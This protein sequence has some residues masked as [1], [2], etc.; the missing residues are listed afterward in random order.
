MYRKAHTYVLQVPH[1][2]LKSENVLVTSSLSV[3]ITDFA[4]SF[5]QVYLPLN[6]PSDFNFYFGTSGRRT[7][8][9]APERFYS[10]DS[11]IA[12]QKAKARA[13]VEANASAS[14]ITNDVEGAPEL[15]K[16]D[17]KVTEAMDVFSLGCVIAELW[18]DGAPIFTLMQLFKYREGLF[19][20]EPALAEI[21]DKDIRD[22]VRSMISIDPQKRKSFAEYLEHGRRKP[23]ADIFYTFLHRYLTTLQRTSPRATAMAAAE[24]AHSAS[25]AAVAAA[26]VANVA[27]GTHGAP[28]TMVSEAG[29]VSNSGNADLAYTLRAEA[30]ERVERLYEEWTV[31]IGMLNGTMAS[32]D[33][34]AI[35]N[36][37]NMDGAFSPRQRTATPFSDAGVGLSEGRHSD[38]KDREDLNRMLPIRISIPGISSKLIR[39]AIPIEEDG[40]ALLILSPLLANM[41]NALRPSTKLHALDLLLHLSSQWL[42]D[43]TKLDRVLPYIIALFNDDSV[44]VRSAA[45][46][47]VVQLLLMVD[48]ITFSNALTFSEYVIPNLRPLTRD[49]SSLVRSTYAACIVHLIEIGKHYLQMASAMRGENYSKADVE[50]EAVQDHK[51]DEFLDGNTSPDNAR[52]DWQ[53]ASLRAFFQEQATILL[54]DSSPAVKR[55][56]LDSI[57]PLCIFFGAGPTNDVL[58]SHM[59]TYLNDRSWLLRHAFFDAIIHVAKVAGPRS[60]EEYILPLMLQTLSDPEEFVVLRVIEGL[61]RLL[62]SD[63]ILS[64]GRIYDIVSAVAGFLCHP[65]H[66][67]R[68][69]SAL[70]IST[71]SSLLPSTDVWA[72]VYPSVR[73]LLRCEV[74]SL[75]ASNL[76]FAVQDPLSRE[77]VQKAVQWAFR[78]KSSA[79]WKAPALGSKGRAGLSNGLGIEGTGL[80][81]GRK[82]K[83]VTRTPI[84]RSEEDDGYLDNLRSSGL[85]ENDEVKLVGLRDYIARLARMSSLI[86]KTSTKDANGYTTLSVNQEDTNLLPPLQINSGLA[87]QPLDDVTPL[88]IF[89]STRSTNR[90]GAG[91][92]PASALPG[93]GSVTGP[94]GSIRSQV[95]DSTFSGRMARRRLGGGRIASDTSYMSPLEELRRR[96]NETSIS[97]NADVALPYTPTSATIDGNGIRPSSPVSISSVVGATHHAGQ[98]KLGLGK[99]LPA[100]ASI[101]TTATGTMSELSA[102]LGSIDRKVPSNILV[103]GQNTPVESATQTVRGAATGRSRLKGQE[104]E[105]G[106]VSTFTSTYEGHDP[107]IQAHLEAIYFANFRDKHPALGPTVTNTAASGIRRRGGRSLSSNA[108]ANTSGSSNRRP[109]GNLIAYFTEHTASITAIAVSPDSAFFLSGSEDGT[110][111]L[112]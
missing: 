72:I 61:N 81:A 59:I 112:R 40:P 35:A 24:A 57:G 105:V 54:T 67:L 60:V 34:F 110:S 47:S 41:R 36:T 80:L 38:E 28:S 19:D 96:M 77:V 95:A 86:T 108:R 109:E 111:T 10:E 50:A 66:W 68:S 82:G 25:A 46:K 103:S 73:P 98:A 106:E 69:M 37:S 29:M 32:T 107:Y 76:L 88:T 53:M 84:Q 17:G 30:D 43:E 13:E 62:E 90:K 78:A 93:S 89:F 74:H 22:M 56:L 48:I 7:C 9:I 64:K 18:R 16:R 51:V 33:Q 44:L 2:D 23:F 27:S 70:V 100:I 49:I 12:K 52:Y 92:S 63:G 39:S 83:G 104:E 45:I 99:A 75:S 8:Y 20:V 31:V 5:K 102:R 55:T 97:D 14:T 11:D 65:N 4:S 71:A 58:L 21:V 42:S 79:F 15:F 87:I 85:N 94:G 26:A 101:S 1:G 91:A 6:D 3:Y